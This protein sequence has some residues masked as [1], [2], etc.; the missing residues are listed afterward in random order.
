MSRLL[1]IDR[2]IRGG[3]YPNAVRL[4]G[5]LEVTHRTVQR[6]IAFL[7]DELRAPLRFDR[8]RNGFHY[9]EPTWP[10]PLV[11]LD[12]GELLALFVAERVLRQYAGTPFAD[13]L[14]AAFAKLTAPLAG[15]V[16]FDPKAWSAAVSVRPAR[17]VREADARLFGTLTEAVRER[18]GL[19]IEYFTASRGAWS[20]RNVDPLHVAV[21]GDDV[22]LAAWC[23]TRRSVRSFSLH[24]IRSARPTGETFR[25]PADFAPARYF[26]AAFRSLVGDG[27]P[28]RVRLLFEPAAARYVRER[29]WHP[30]Q[31]EADRPDGRTEVTL[32][33][34]DLREVRSWV[35]SWGAACRVLEPAE[36]RGQ[37]VAELES[38]L[39]NYRAEP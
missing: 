5:L 13:E 35:L 18:R 10:M 29:R 8:D 4:A 24:R 20:T 1:A 15:E 26:D 19:R 33:V 9:T 12:A 30:S 14:Q 16:T 11:R 6:D 3:G 31:A 25:P 34:S 21:L 28:R 7:R 32:E 23:H 22:Q 2:A 27:R 36:L 38:A 39:R 37:V 17:P